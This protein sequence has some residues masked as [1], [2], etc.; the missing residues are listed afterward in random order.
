MKTEFHTL[1]T[2][3]HATGYTEGLII[4]SHGS[5][6]I[7]RKSFTPKLLQKPGGRP[8]FRWNKTSKRQTKQQINSVFWLFWLEKPVWPS[9]PENQTHT[10][11]NFNFSLVF[12]NVFDNLFSLIFYNYRIYEVSPYITIQ[13]S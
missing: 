7:Q 4:N 1:K 6:F 3:Q 2:E 5:H 12:K 10:E 13:V 8:K 11:Y 9:P